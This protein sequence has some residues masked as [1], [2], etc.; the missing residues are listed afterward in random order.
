MGEY[1]DFYFCGNHSFNDGEGAHDGVNDDGGGEGEGEGAGAGAGEGDGAG[2]G[3]A[4]GDDDIDRAV[5]RG[6]GGRSTKSSS[7]TDHR[8]GDEGVGARD[9]E[10]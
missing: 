4:D 1:F 2:D 7:A 9:L 6:W 5:R 3:G 8:G 10:E